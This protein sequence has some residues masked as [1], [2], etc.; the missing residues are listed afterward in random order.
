MGSP[1]IPRVFYG[2]PPYYSVFMGLTP[3]PVSFCGA[4]APA[5]R[6][7]RA[8]AG[9]VAE[10]RAR[11]GALGGGRPC[12]APLPDQGPFQPCAGPRLGPPCCPPY[13]KERL[14]A[15]HRAQGRPETQQEPAVII[16][17]IWGQRTA[18]RA[19]M[20]SWGADPQVVGFGDLRTDGGP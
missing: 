5:L 17:G 10:C 19:L 13:Q 15:A 14:R 20:G 8:A 18:L 9:D 16:G 7:L 2:L 4:A 12:R 11:P 1:Q 3:N 6:H